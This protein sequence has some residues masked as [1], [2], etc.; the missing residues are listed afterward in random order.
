MSPSAEHCSSPPGQII[1]AL[2]D[3]SLWSK[4]GNQNDSSFICHYLRPH[5]GLLPQISLFTSSYLCHII[6]LVKRRYFFLSLQRNFEICGILKTILLPHDIQHIPGNP[7]N[8]TSGFCVN[9]RPPI[10]KLQIHS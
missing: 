2:V 8:R 5:C 4:A 1:Y 6:N 3:D 9:M 10:V 7:N